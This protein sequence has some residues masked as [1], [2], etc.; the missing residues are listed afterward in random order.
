MTDS[1][2][3]RRA[4][5]RGLQA[6]L[7][8]AF[9]SRSAPHAEAAQSGWPFRAA[10]GPFQ[11]VSE[12]P[13]DRIDP[14]FRELSLL[15]QQLIRTLGLPPSQRPV[16]VALFANEESHRRYLSR[17]YPRVPYRRALYVQRGGRGAVFAYFHAQLADDLRHECTHALL[18][19]K[20]PMVPLWLDEGLAEY[21]EVAPNLRARNNPHLARLRWDLFFGLQHSVENL[22]RQHELSDMGAAEYRFSWAWTHFMLHGPP[23]AHEQLVLYLADIRQGNP[24]GMLSERLH[25]CIPNLDAQLAQHFK[26]WKA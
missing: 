25:R 18:H 19:A 24:P 4:L 15:E 2:T 6:V 26:T 10:Y 5:Q 14:M 16:E 3:R 13:L 20:L 11:C 9:W 21:F 12:A 17:V 1:I 23:V 22:E 7:G 8:A